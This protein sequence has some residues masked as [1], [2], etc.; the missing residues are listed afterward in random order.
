MNRS[1]HFIPT[2]PYI[3]EFI[4]LLSEYKKSNLPIIL[5]A[6]PCVRPGSDPLHPILHAYQY[7]FYQPGYTAELVVPVEMKKAIDKR[8]DG[9]ATIIETPAS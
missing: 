2:E 4:R 8:L 7:W 6:V 5:F 1:I 3:A 9:L